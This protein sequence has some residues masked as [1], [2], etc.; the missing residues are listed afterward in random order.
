[1]KIEL[2]NHWKSLLQTVFQDGTDFDVVD[3]DASYFRAKVRWKV[4]TDPDRPNKMSKTIIITVPREAASDYA[5]K[6]DDQRRSDDTKLREFVKSKLANHDPDHDNPKD[7]KPPKVEWLAGSN[8]L[9][10]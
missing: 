7:S 1:M 10:S 9:N 5:N 2:K 4:G 8:V 6:N 3:P